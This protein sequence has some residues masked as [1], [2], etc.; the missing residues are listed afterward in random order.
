M[1]TGLLAIVTFLGGFAGA[2]LTNLINARMADKARKES[3]RKDRETY[4]SNSLK[5]LIELRGKLEYL[6]D[7]GLSIVQ[8]TPSRLDAGKERDEALGE[9]YAILRGI[10]DT[11]IRQILSD[12]NLL[13]YRTDENG[14]VTIDPLTVLNARATQ[15]R[16]LDKAIERLGDLLDEIM[17]V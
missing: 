1:D 4:I 14:R 6:F 3:R 17:G 15:L 10:R 5:R 12:E 16:T 13:P 9:A 11:P 2:G 7:K 8:D